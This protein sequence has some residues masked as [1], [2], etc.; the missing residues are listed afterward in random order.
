MFSQNLILSFTRA[1]AA[2]C[3]NVGGIFDI[4]GFGNTAGCL[5]YCSI[6]S[7]ASCTNDLGFVFGRIVC[8]NL[9]AANF[10]SD[11]RLDNLVDATVFGLAMNLEPVGLAVTSALLLIFLLI[12][13]R[14][15][16][17]SVPIAL[18]LVL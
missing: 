9:L 5:I 16:G 13:I 8:S 4:L 3:F 18:L 14:A 6:F 2:S 17:T 12:P 10:V 7:A 1:C 15:V 11:F